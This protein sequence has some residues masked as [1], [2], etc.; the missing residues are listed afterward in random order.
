MRLALLLVGLLIGFGFPGCSSAPGPDPAEPT[1]KGPP[2][3]CVAAEARLES[4]D[5]R[6]PR[7]DPMWENRRGE[8]FADTCHTLQDEGGV[9]VDPECIANAATCEEAN[10][11]PIG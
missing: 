3:W 6:D 7:G 10:A 1:T 5:C 4:L 11:C 9:F 2:D 8:R